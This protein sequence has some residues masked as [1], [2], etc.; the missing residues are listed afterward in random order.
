M[1]NTK[2]LIKILFLSLLLFSCNEDNNK[3]DNKTTHNHSYNKI[4]VLNIGT[5]HMGYTTDLHKSEFDTNSK[6]N[7][8]QIEELCQ[9]IATF[10]PT[11]ICV[12]Y[13]YL[14][15]PDIQNLYEKYLNNKDLK[16]YGLREIELLAFRIGQISKTKRIYGIDYFDENKGH[17]YMKIDEMAKSLNKKTYLDFQNKIIKKVN[18]N[19]K[20]LKKGLL[21]EFLYNLNQK[22]ELD[23]LIVFNAEILSH[24]NT[25]E[26][27]EG[28]DEAAKFYQRNIRM[29]ANLNKLKF[30]KNDRVF[31]LLGGTHAAYFNDFLERSPKYKLVNCQ[32]YLR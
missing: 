30:T 16:E 23:D 3:V 29:Y 10:K 13:P 6:K 17:D 21:I 12:E 5:F 26:G 24:V 7:K 15:K 32:D 22:E 14:S 19:N 27:F 8:S 9:K 31:I 4:K 1:S 18:Q 25:K 20:I 11:V 2:K 28:A